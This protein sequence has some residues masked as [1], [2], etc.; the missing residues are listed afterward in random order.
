MADISDE[1]ITAAVEDGAEAFWAVIAKQFPEA[2]SGDFP[3]DAE[4]AL[5]KALE[6]AVRVW[7][8]ANVESDD[9]QSNIGLVS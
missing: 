4:Y 3:P 9:E 5:T 1:R 8:D 6:E 7:L 2:T